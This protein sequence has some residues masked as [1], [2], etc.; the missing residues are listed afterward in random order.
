MNRLGCCRVTLASGSRLGAYEIVGSLGAGG[1]G[2]VYRALDTRLHRTVAIKVLASDVRSDPERRRRFH[3]EAQAVAA[4]SHP[5]IAGLHDIGEHEGTDFLVLELVEGQTLAARLAEKP[6]T[7]PEALAYGEQIAQALDH[8]H[9]HAIVHRDLK[10]QNV[11]ITKTGAKLLDFGLA[12]LA[13]PAV[14]VAG[15]GP[16]GPPR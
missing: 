7:V 11:M 12:R 2:E 6:L 4:L 14:D 15:H 10:P 8:A 9:R 5:H 1:M 3:R 13:K 16:T